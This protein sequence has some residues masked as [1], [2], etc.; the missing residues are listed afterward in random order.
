M[1]K[2]F[3]INPSTMLNVGHIASIEVHPDGQGI[4]FTS[5][6]KAYSIA[7]SK[8]TELIELLTETNEEY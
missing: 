7:G 4:V 8:V 2:L 3:L 5:N 1:T 6:G